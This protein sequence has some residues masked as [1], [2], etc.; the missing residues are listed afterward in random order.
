LPQSDG[1]C[2]LPPICIDPAPGVNETFY[3]RGR[4]QMTKPPK[5]Y[6][7]V[8]GLLVLW[9]LV[10]CYS[11]LAQVM[12]TPADLA[13]LPEAQRDMIRT[14]PTWLT[15]LY[16]IAV[17]SALAGAICLLLRLT[18]APTA[19]LV[20][21]VAV[22]IQFGWI[23]GATQ[24]IKTMGFAEAAGSPIFIAIVG[25]ASVWFARLAKGRGWLR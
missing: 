21:L 23:L 7:A 11:Y 2:K 16:A 14:L 24:I 3:N 19:Y 17:W 20:S 12:M 18:F 5:W 9:A 22:I 10:G 25:A 15:A 4:D 8:T 13:N 6:F 1:A